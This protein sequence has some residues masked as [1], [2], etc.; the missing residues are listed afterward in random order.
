MPNALP[1]QTVNDVIIETVERCCNP[2]K[3]RDNRLNDVTLTPQH[4]S[5][6]GSKPNNTGRFRLAAR[7]S[8][9]TED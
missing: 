3:K 8:L 5:T 7:D 4:L 2:S 9:H 1:A 6:A